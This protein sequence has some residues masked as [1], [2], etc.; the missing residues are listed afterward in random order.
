VDGGSKVQTTMS[1][2]W[3]SSA[4]AAPRSVT[5]QAGFELGLD[6][7]TLLATS[8]VSRGGQPVGETPP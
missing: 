5:A 6:G 2:Q 7:D 4:T 8:A 3:T 1:H